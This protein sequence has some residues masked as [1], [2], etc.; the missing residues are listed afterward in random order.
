MASGVDTE[1]LGSVNSTAY[2]RR[3]YD[4]MAGMI[5]GDAPAF[6]NVMDSDTALEVELNQ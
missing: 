2:L 6:E 1:S 4:R 5:I 3:D